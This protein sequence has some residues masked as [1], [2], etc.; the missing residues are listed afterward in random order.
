LPASWWVTSACEE[1]VDATYSA[2]DVVEE[3]L[4]EL[5]KPSLIVC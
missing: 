1:S 3:L 5:G 2:V 4:R